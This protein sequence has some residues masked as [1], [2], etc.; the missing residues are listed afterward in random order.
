MRWLPLL[1][2]HSFFCRNAIAAPDRF[3]RD[4]AT[5]PGAAYLKF[6]HHKRRIR[7]RNFKWK[8]GTRIN[9]FSSA[10]DFPKFVEAGAAMEYELR[11][12]GTSVV[13]GRFD[14]KSHDFYDFC[15]HKILKSDPTPLSKAGRRWYIPPATSR[16]PAAKGCLLRKPLDGSGALG[17]CLS[18]FGF[19]EKGTTDLSRGGAAR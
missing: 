15:C 11:K 19:F 5:S 3:S 2:S 8:S 13:S 7:S 6:L 16:P 14:E 9:K 4:D 18:R 12:V 1:P 17:R 10:H